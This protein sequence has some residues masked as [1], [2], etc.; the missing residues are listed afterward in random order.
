MDGDCTFSE[1]QA[2]AATLCVKKPCSPAMA[3]DLP[4]TAFFHGKLHINHRLIYTKW[5]FLGAVSWV[6][7]TDILGRD[8]P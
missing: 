4:K 2:N 1:I 8:E 5:L 3:I 7:N 6:I